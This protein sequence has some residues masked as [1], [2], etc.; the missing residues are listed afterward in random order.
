MQAVGTLTST[1]SPPPAFAPAPS[2]NLDEVSFCADTAISLTSHPK[3]VRRQQGL[4]VAKE[5]I[6]HQR[7][8]EEAGDHSDPQKAS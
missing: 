5:H 3:L 1:L 4:W 2:V 6:Q 8:Q 7:E